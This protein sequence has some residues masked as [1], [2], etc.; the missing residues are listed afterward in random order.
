MYEHVPFSFHMSL[1]DKT[2]DVF[3]SYTF[4]VEHV[5]PGKFLATIIQDFSY[6]CVHV[7]THVIV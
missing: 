5:G 1:I 7:C 4:G 3:Y 6:P 2:S